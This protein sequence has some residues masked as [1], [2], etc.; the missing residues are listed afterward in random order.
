MSLN[1]FVLSLSREGGREPF[2]S[3]SASQSKNQNSAFLLFQTIMLSFLVLVNKG[4]FMFIYHNPYQNNFQQNLT[5]LPC[6]WCYHDVD[7]LC[8]RPRFLLCQTAFFL[9]SHFFENIFENLFYH[10][11]EHTLQYL[12]KYLN[13]QNVRSVFTSWRINRL[14]Y[15]CF[16][17]KCLWVFCKVWVFKGFIVSLLHFRIFDEEPTVSFEVLSYCHNNRAI[18]QNSL[19]R[20]SECRVHESIVFNLHHHLKCPL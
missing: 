9:K 20:Q 17:Y 1:V 4:F 3:F 12:I 18:F 6:S 10:L 2:A 14:F 7:V 11:I 8:I 5:F 13:G 15:S 16:F 19:L